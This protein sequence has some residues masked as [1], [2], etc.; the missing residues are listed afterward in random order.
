[1]AGE[2]LE[3]SS[4]QT[5]KASDYIISGGRDF[6][7]KQGAESRQ[8]LNGEVATPIQIVV[9]FEGIDPLVLSMAAF[10]D[11]E[12]PRT[13]WVTDLADFLVVRDFL[14]DPAPFLHYATIRSDPSR[15]MPYMESDGVVGYLEDRLT[16]ESESA[17]PAFEPEG[18]EGASLPAVLRYNSGLINDYYTKAELGFPAERLGLGFPEEVRGGLRVTGVRDNSLLWWQVAAAILDMTPADWGKWKH[19]NRR[20]R[21]DRPFSPSSQDVGIVHSSAAAEPQIVGGERPTLVLP[22]AS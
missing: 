1:V 9:S 11:S 12:V 6:A 22:V 10:I 20:D 18:P 8:L 5:G 13:V 19:F 16:G 7:P 4:T 2:V 17:V 3:R 14:G 21:T 15:P